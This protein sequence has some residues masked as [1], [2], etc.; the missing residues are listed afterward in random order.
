M[1]SY[2]TVN[3]YAANTILSLMQPTAMTSGSLLNTATSLSPASSSAAATAAAVRKS[4][5]SDRK[6]VF[7][8]RAVC[9]AP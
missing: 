2:K 7:L 1:T 4:S 6:S 9:P 3:A 8:Q 5:V